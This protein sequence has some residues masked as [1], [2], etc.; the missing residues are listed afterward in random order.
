MH[1]LPHSLAVFCLLSIASDH[2]LAA[3]GTAS[4]VSRSIPLL[5]RAQP[6]RTADESLAW[7][8]NQRESLVSKY[9]GGSS[10]R[11]RASGTNL[12]TNQRF[13]TSFFGS[14]A[15]GTPPIAFNVILDT[16]SSDLWIASDGGFS[17]GD[18]IVKFDPSNSSTFRDL[19]TPF[20]IRYGSGAAQ[21][22]LGQDVVEMAGFRVVSQTFGVVTDQ[23]GVL[24]PPLSGLMGMG[25][26]SIA[27]SGASP[28]WQ[29][30]VG[31]DGVLDEPLMA[32]Q[33][34]RFLDVREA[35]DLEPGGTFTIGA[36]D[37]SLFTGEIDYQPIPDGFAGYWIQEIAEIT[38]NGE[39]VPL[40]AGT[41][42]YGAIDTGTTLVTGPPSVIDA[43]YAQIPN[44][45]ALTGDAEGFYQFPCA[46][47][48]QVT[49][50]FGASAISWPI[51]P[52]DFV[53]GTGLGPGMCIGGFIALSTAGTSAPSFI[54]GDTFLKNVYSV[55]RAQ[56]PSVGFAVLSDAAA[57]MN[58]PLGPVPTPT[59]GEVAA[60]VAA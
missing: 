21:G 26:Q 34:T 13:D 53:V 29:T 35:R 48:V 50:R 10:Q 6:Q 3:P 12:L 16:G 60:T 31:E 22:T 5:R 58:V 24:T 14:I 15:V 17:I 19:Q 4:S 43:L 28:F 37:S 25:F 46:T 33:F 59:I 45:Q 41:G 55:Y 52:V 20:Q 8:K 27:S 56:P 9:G 51:S 40:L 39:P 32:F 54:V 57:A 18:D 23:Q 42:S 44:S 1:L 47:D 38:V 49:M 30:L 36:V 11:K 2:A 7:L